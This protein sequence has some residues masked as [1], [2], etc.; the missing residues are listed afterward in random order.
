MMLLSWL[1]PTV[2][3][4]FGNE[5][6]C[7]SPVSCSQKIVLFFFK[8]VFLFKD[9]Q[10]RVWGWYRW[11]SGKA[12]W[13]PRTP[14]GHWLLQV[15]F[16]QLISTHPWG[17]V[18]SWL[19]FHLDPALPKKTLLLPFWPCPQQI[20]ITPSKSLPRTRCSF[21]STFWKKGATSFNIAK[22]EFQVC[23]WLALWSWLSI[24]WTNI[25]NGPTMCHAPATP[26]R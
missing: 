1:P 23:H 26:W 14:S 3:L 24:Y 9:P 6:P 7:L 12:V 2:H 8:F 17:E 4:G 21:G 20:H 13:G 19:S 25:Y 18:P 10:W 22:K 15:P 16:G 11:A 5:N